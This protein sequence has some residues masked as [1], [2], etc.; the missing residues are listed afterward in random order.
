M[1]MSTDPQGRREPRSPFTHILV[2]IDGSDTSINAGRLAI[3]IAASQDIPITFLYVVDTSAADKIAEATATATQTMDQQLK[4][5]GQ[6]YLDYLSRQARDRGLAADQVV[7]HGIPHSEIAN[8]AR[9]RD[10]DLIVIG[11][12]GRQRQLRIGNVAER[13]IEYAPCPVLVV[14]YTPIQQS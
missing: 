4:D 9:E 11:Q 2:P 8:F 1:S 14:K 6:R 7:L 3:Q 5:K 13:V 12:V 10:I